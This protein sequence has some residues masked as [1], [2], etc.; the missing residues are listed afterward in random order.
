MLYFLLFSLRNL[1]LKLVIS[2][3]NSGSPA[4]SGEL[5]LVFLDSPRGCAPDGLILAGFG[6]VFGGLAASSG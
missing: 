1:T 4:S 5:S 2:G 6:A 3:S